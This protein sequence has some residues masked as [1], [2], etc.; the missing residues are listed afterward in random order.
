MCEVLVNLT[1]ALAFPKIDAKTPSPAFPVVRA[2]DD[3]SVGAGRPVMAA[4]RFGA[5][6]VFV[7]GDLTAFVPFRIGHADN[8]ALLLNAFGWLT[9]RPVDAAVREA[10]ARSPFLTEADARHIREE[11]R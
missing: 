2:P 11:E 9:N 4:A 10:F 5:G 8:A 1:C 3:A 6:R 7:C